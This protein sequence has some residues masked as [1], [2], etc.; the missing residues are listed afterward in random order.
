ME[1]P[2]F[3]HI[4]ADFDA[5]A[6]ETTIYKAIL[7]ARFP[8]S[9]IIFTHQPFKKGDVISPA[10]Y[11]RMVCSSFPKHCV[12]LCLLHIG[13]RLP[14]K[15]V[16]ARTPD[17]YF[18]IP[19][20]GILSIAFPQAVIEYYKLSSTQGVKDICRELYLP[21]LENLVAD[22]T[23]LPEKEDKPK[24]SLLPQPTLTGNTYR[25]TVLHNDSQGNAYLNMQKEEFERITL[26]K[27]FSIKLGMKES[28]EN[29]SVTY[30]DVSEGSKLA[31]FGLG[32]MLQIAVNCGSAAQY[33]GLKTGQMVMLV[34]E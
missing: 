14:E 8:G 28:I 9:T 7:H 22:S 31:L 4:L 5:L 17:Q 23:Q 33:L 25:L 30:T 32:D 34:V 29:I 6:P 20:N 11:L 3:I 24:I 15:Y 10:I 26:S 12:H 27:K 18:F 21:V 16:L 2:L 1:N 13:N 19:D